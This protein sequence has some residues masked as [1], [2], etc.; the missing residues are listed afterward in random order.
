MEKFALLN[1]LNALNSLTAKPA[2]DSTDN[3]TQ[4][5]GNF[6]AGNVQSNGAAP[7]AGAGFGGNGGASFGTGFGGGAANAPAEHTYPNVMASVLE[8]HEAISN[9]VKNK[10]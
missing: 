10:K 8:R 7:A 6:T 3:G 9:R 4:A 2:A 5:A 1:L